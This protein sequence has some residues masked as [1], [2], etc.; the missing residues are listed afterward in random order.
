V[1]TSHLVASALEKNP[2]GH[3]PLHVLAFI[4]VLLPNAPASQGLHVAAP[5]ALYLP[6]VQMYVAGDGVV[7]PDSG[8]A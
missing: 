1:H 8:H 7:E 2:A 4:A 5:A 6:G 3:S